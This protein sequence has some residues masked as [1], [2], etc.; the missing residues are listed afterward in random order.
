SAGLA[1]L[2][3]H[4]WVLNR[5]FADL[6]EEVYDHGGDV[7]YIAGDAFLCYWPAASRDALGE[8][9]LR[10]AQAGLAIQ[11]RLHE[12]DAGRGHR[13]ATRIGLSAGEL[14]IAFVGGVG[15]RWELVADGRALHEAAEAERASAPGEVV[16][17]PAAWAL[18]ARR[19]DGHRRGDAG[20][21]LAA[22]REGLPALV[23]PAQQEA[24]ADEQLL[25]AFVPPSVL[26]R[27]DSEAASLAELR[28]VT[29]LMADLPGLGDAT[30][31][32]LERTHAHV[33]AFQQV[34]E[35]FEGIVRVD[36][37]DKGVML[38]AVFGLPPR[39]HEN[40]AVRAIHAARA[41]REAL[42]ALGVRCGIGV[43]TG[44]A[45]CGAFGS[46]LR[47]EYMLRGDV[48]NL[49]ARLMQAAGA[50]VV[51]DQATVQSARGRIDFE[52]MAP[53]VLKGR[54]QPVPAYRPL[55]RSERVTR[56]ASPIIGR[57]R[58]RSVLEAQVVA[59]REGASGGL[60]IV[61]AEAGVGKSRLM[62]DLSARAEAVGVR[63]LTATADAIESNTAYYAWRQVFGALFGLDSSVRGADARARVV[64][65]MA[66][67]SGVAQLLPL[68]NAVLA[69]QIPDNELTQ[70][71]VGEVREENT[72]HLLA[73]VL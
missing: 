60:A 24:S 59:L 69:V 55:G 73:K 7:L 26:D 4:T 58:E 52:A 48:I 22:I 62:A 1:G 68:L 11:A 38:L 33:R 43:A 54:S 32:N 17:S 14:S 37:D 42:E 18:V 66:S 12:R 21:V 36:V 8:T 45:F 30:P 13:F 67:L 29:V 15:G 20:T 53:L 64:E 34:V 72:R 31:A 16:L 56:A 46:D 49:A 57:L 63:V 5:Y 70:E 6:L 27:L 40:D 41:L 44:R 51:C 50:A 61:E 28:A 25:R 35:R 10:A 71:M 19:C 65:K 47:R 9:V 2:E 23:R 3:Q 39:A